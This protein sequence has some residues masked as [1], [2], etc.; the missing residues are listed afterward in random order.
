MLMMLIRGE[1]SLLYI[2]TNLLYMS[3]KKRD[4]KKLE[5]KIYS[6]LKSNPSKVYNYKQLSSCFDVKDTK[7]R[8]FIIRILSDLQRKGKIELRDRGKYFFDP[9]KIQTKEGTLNLL[10]TGKGVISF[11]EEKQDYIVPKQYI[12]LGP[13]L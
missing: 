11:V 5:K 1:S 7:T 9:K 13:E 10:P 3:K 4:I 6:F 2:C 12:T 8:N